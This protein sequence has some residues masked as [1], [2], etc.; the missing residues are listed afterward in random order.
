[1]Q[2]QY[3]NIHIF[4]CIILVDINFNKNCKFRHMSSRHSCLNLCTQNI[5][6]N[7][8]PRFQN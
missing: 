3:G 6:L 1:M 2:K 8:N 4:R 5:Y 7:L